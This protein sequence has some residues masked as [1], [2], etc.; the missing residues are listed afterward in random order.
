MLDIIVEGG[1]VVDGTGAEGVASD[2][3]IDGDRIADI[4]DL[5]DVEAVRR[6]D[7]NGLTVSPGFID[8]HT[9]SDFSL[10]VNGRA[11]SQIHQGVTTEVVG[12]CGHSC[13]PCADKARLKSAIFGYH[14]DGEITWSTFDQYL[15]ALEVQQLGVNVAAYV[16]HGTLRIAAMDGE[17]RP[18]EAS[19]TKAMKALLEDSLQAGAI[20]FSTGLEY[21][22]GSAA[23][24]EEIVELCEVVARYDRIHATH[25]R[26]RDV[27]YRQGFGEAL[28]VAKAANIRSQISHIVPKYGAPA[29][30]MEETLGAVE[31]HNRNDSK[32][33]FDIIPHEWGPTTMS[34]VLPNWA[35]DGGISKTLDR[36]RDPVVRE[37]LKH[38]DNPIW[39]LVG[40]GRWDRIKF[41]NSGANPDLVGFTFDE[42]Q[43]K[44]G[45]SGL[46]LVFDLL[47]EEGEA[48]FNATWI[49][50]NFSQHDI[51]LAMRQASC[52]II[53]D[54]ITLAPYGAYKDTKW[55][56]STYGWAACFFGKYVRD[57]KILPVEEAVHRVTGLAAESVGLIGRGVLR[58]G[59]KA[60]VTIFDPTKIQDI[61]TT[62]DPN[63]FPIGID[64]VLVN[65]RVAIDD[66]ER[67]EVNAGRVLRAA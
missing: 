40:D 20:G 5:K 67:T 27:D 52:G 39:Q 31:R 50:H 18:A 17:S 32:V 43:R 47:L 2:I 8:I 37:S 14:D 60:D 6:I 24:A 46:D 4:G 51:L 12:N 9:H 26:N 28:T 30:A 34:S 35:F 48:L 25:V 29:E 44:R 66:G 57:M 36:L 33:T 19:E 56:P 13:A 55:S 54:T 62:N 22:P 21:A 64:T 61:S 49:A 7:A 59:H 11:E 45:V 15:S 41:F 58:R 42:L 53:S 23:T 1:W 10:I 65:G 16:G 38:N 3:G 63:V